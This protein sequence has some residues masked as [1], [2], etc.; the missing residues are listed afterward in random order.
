MPRECLSRPD[1]EPQ[2][3]G[4]PFATFSF[5]AKPLSLFRSALLMEAKQLN[6]DMLRRLAGYRILRPS[7]RPV[8]LQNTVRTVSRRRFR[9]RHRRDNPI[10]RDAREIIFEFPPILHLYQ[11][12]I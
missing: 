1:P 12:S 11:R 8:F 10:L 9:H 5:S 3:S 6:R 2:G 4:F 7:V